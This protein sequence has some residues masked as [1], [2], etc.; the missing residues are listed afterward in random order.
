VETGFPGEIM[1]RIMIQGAPMHSTPNRDP[2]NPDDVLV[3]RADER[4]AH[5]Y[6]KIT[7]AD[8]Q[9]TRVSA[10][11]SRMERDAARHPSAASGRQPSR[12]RPVLR[13]LVG[14]VLAACI[15]AAA[16]ALQSPNGAAGRLK[17]AQWLPHATSAASP[18]NPADAVSPTLAAVQA[19]ADAV[20]PTSSQAPVQGVA[21]APPPPELT[22]L[23]QGMAHDIATLEQG[24]EQLKAGQE[25]M[26]AE[27]AQAIEQLKASQEQIARLVAKP[28]EKPV[29]PDPRAK[30]PV[31]PVRPVASNAVRK[32][33]PIQPAAQA[34][35]RP[36]AQ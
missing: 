12:G 24:I 1:N 15:I 17:I 16:F 18:N 8:E 6:A 2:G 21:P 14:V 20:P 13:G 33:L 34:K 11:L 31:P 10:Q 23:L 29:A 9:L 32:P 36:N 22:Q 7:D 27:N 19:A 26:A 3:A 5:A 4:L 30:T 35:G 25:R 28:S